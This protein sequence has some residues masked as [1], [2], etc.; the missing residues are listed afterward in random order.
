VVHGLLR[1]LTRVDPDVNKVAITINV[2]RGSFVAGAGGAVAVGDAAVWAAYSD[3]TVAKV[4]PDVNRVV[5]TD[6]AGRSPAGAAFGAGSLWVANHAQNTVSRFDPRSFGKGKNAVIDVGRGPSGVAFGGG[7]VWVAN[8][9]DDS[10]SRIDP[11]TRVVRRVSVGDAPIAVAYG[12][13]SVWVADRGD[14]T[15]KR[16]D[17]RSG[18]V[19]A[20]IH[21]G[22]SPSGIAVEEGLVWVSVDAR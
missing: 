16:L 11:S 18:K 7:Y 17:P 15:V 8:T 2:T 20:T 21:V 4:D 14:G 5:A 13:D 1:K 19:N 6:F 12:V 3:A 10:V 22:N 9:D